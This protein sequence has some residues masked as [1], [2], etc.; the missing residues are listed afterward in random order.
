[1]W[2]VRLRS[3]ELQPSVEET[4]HHMSSPCTVSPFSDKM[5]VAGM[6]SVPHRPFPLVFYSLPNAPLHRTYPYIH[7]MAFS[8]C[9][10]GTHVT[11]FPSN[12]DLKDN[13]FY[14]FCHN[15]RHS[16]APSSFS[17]KE[18]VKRSH[19]IIDTYSGRE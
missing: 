13:H 19:I 3:P 11:S 12:L 9:M 18:P 1:M 7:P 5:C 2:C 14:C 17:V 8:F 10:S 16:L 6:N 4:H 15:I